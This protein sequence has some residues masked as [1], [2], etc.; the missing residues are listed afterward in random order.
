M[1]NM[2]KNVIHD[3]YE[4][5]PHHKKRILWYIINATIFRCMVT[6]L[7]RRPRN[8]LLRLFGAKIHKQAI[9]Y[10]SV[11]IF[12][13]WNLELG[14]CTIGPGVEL[15]DKDI[16]RIGDDSVV[17]QQSVLCTASH[18]VSSPMM[19]LVTKPITL[20]NRVWVAMD[21]FIGPGVELADGVV[22]GARG[23]VFR[24]VD[25]WTIVGGNPAKVI[26]QRELKD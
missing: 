4:P 6:G 14:R 21:A 13:P 15:Y 16:I 8:A 20:G 7:M 2:E 22:V 9:I 19:A 24:S 10:S 3:Y 1:S 17:S 5:K 12:A 26:G 25:E 23:C 11:K 18:D